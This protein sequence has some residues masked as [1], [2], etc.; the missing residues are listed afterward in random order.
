MYTTSIEHFAG[1]AV[2]LAAIFRLYHRSSKSR[3]RDIPK[4]P[5]FN[6]P[7]IIQVIKLIFTDT[8][9]VDIGLEYVEMVQNKPYRRLT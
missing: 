8:D 7:S 6:T 2:A 5:G 9:E 4:E 3:Y 1:L